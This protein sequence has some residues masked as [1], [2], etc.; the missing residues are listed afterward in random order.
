VE[1]EWDSVKAEQNLRKHGVSFEDAARV[2]LDPDRIEASTEARIMGKID[3]EPL[4]WLER[5]CW[6]C[7]YGSR[8]QGEVVRLI[9]ARKASANECAEYVKFRLDPKGKLTTRQLKRLAAIATMPD[10]KID[11][12][13]ISESSG[14]CV[15][16]KPGALIPSENKQQITLRWTR[17]CSVFSGKQEPAIKA[18][19][20]RL[21]ESI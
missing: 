13:D 10:S 14:A 7:L 4:V 19:S 21:C 1:F 9:S 20:M 6:C 5:V 8:R 11:Y 15:G 3:G 2:F 16:T 17:M 12:S 18:A